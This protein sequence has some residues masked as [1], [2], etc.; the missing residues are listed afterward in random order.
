[1]PAA[2]GAGPLVL[3]LF[4]LPD[5]TLFPNTLLPLHVF[6]ARYRALVTDAL[7]RDRKLCVVRLEP[8]WEAHYEGRPQV[9]AVA[10]AGAIVGCERLATGRFN[11]VVKGECRV[12]IER[13]LPTDTLYRLARARRLAETGPVADVSPLVDRIRAACRRLLEV[14]GRPAD[15]LAGALAAGLPP[16]VLADRVAAAVIPDG[17]QRQALLE[18]LDVPVRLERLAAALDQLVDELGRPRE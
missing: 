7:A 12:R 14:P 15:I 6:E 4:P 10:G 9:A 2:P 18:A 13:E 17:G 8:G 11:I 1:V 16:G 3:P 5:V